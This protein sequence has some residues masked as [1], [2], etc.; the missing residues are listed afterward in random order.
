MG[1]TLFTPLTG[2]TSTAEFGQ[3][4]ATAALALSTATAELGSVPLDAAS[5]AVMMGLIE[6][7][8]RIACYAQLVVTQRAETAGI[9]QLDPS[10]A[11][12]IDELVATLWPLADGTSTMPP[13]VLRQGMAPYRNTQAFMQAHLH[14]S[15]SEARRRV[16]G[17]RLLVAPPSPGSS[18]KAAPAEPS[19]PILARAASDASADVSNLTTMAGRLESMQPR[20][21]TRSDAE[22]MNAAIEE[23]LARE[24]RTSDPK[25][26][27]QALR[28]WD[29]FL[30][31]NGTP[32][33]DEE[34]RAKRGMFYRGYRDGSDEFLLR[35]APT[36]SEVLLS[37]SEAWTNPRSLKSP[38]FS[39][40]T[41]SGT[42]AD[43]EM[44]VPV[45]GPTRAGG[46]SARPDPLES[47]A[48]GTPTFSPSGTP[49]PEWARAAGTDEADIPLSE[50]EC[51]LPPE[52]SGSDPM[53][54]FD[55]R[56]N[57]QLLLDALIAA[58]TGA[59]N[60]AGIA[61]SGGMRVRVGVLIDYRSLLGQCEDAGLTAHNRPISAANIRRLAC[62]GD[63]LPAVMGENGAVLELGRE[64]RGFTNAQRRAIAIRDRGCVIPG[65]MRP[66]SM[67]ECHHVIPWSEGGP[68]NVSNAA[69]VCEFHHLQVHAGLI[70]LKS[71]DGV[72]H[73]VEIEGQPR[74][75][76]QRNL[77]WH[78][79][80]R[81]AGYQASLFG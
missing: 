70:K 30:S 28:D 69:L 72:P 67:S 19:Y 26:C 34:I 31:E 64:I 37:F 76:P 48:S 52:G 42:T 43:E 61:E 15:T 45:D 53:T 11:Q 5:T 75:A 71:I 44:S 18:H 46:R 20:I 29:N 54:G 10:T 68:T 59:I 1:T 80:L 7:I 21:R 62:D 2:P 8:Y 40:S 77:Y 3:Q 73:V 58:C 47:S 79:R 13:E 25:I 23:S 66:A 6:R 17:G 60:G 4:L 39:T 12:Q 38:P 57:P 24:A 41:T 50:L 49:A 27:G 9:H 51:G 55:V 14:I 32:I 35:C 22:N 81:T 36:D 74:G 63:I 33:S 16:T 78:P 65:C 56:T